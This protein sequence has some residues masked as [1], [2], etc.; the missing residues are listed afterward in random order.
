MNN[1]SDCLSIL[2]SLNLRV[3]P[4]QLEELS[5]RN[6]KKHGR[7]RRATAWELLRGLVVHMLGSPGTF[8]THFE[9][10]NGK[11]MAE[12]SL[13]ERRQMLPW[14][15]FS[16]LME[17]LLTPCAEKDRNSSAFYKGLRLVGIDGSNFSARNTKSILRFCTKALSRRFKAA[18]SKIGVSVLIELGTH[19][20]IGAAIAHAGESEWSLSKQVLARLPKESLLIGDKLFGLPSF[21]REF[22]ENVPEGKFL[23]RV[24]K[25]VL[26][27]TTK[28]LSDGSRL[29]EIHVRRSQK[30][31]STWSMVV[32][33]IRASVGR[34][35]HRHQEVRLWTNLTDEHQYPAIE[36]IELYA[37]RW[38]QELSY[39]EIKHQQ[40][41]GEL[42]DS[43][44]F[45]TVCQE[46]AA[47][48]IAASVIAHQRTN[49]AGNS[50]P[51]TA[52]GFEKALFYTQHLWY[53]LL[54]SDGILTPAQQQE[55]ANRFRKMLTPQTIPKKR[56]RSC[57]RAVRQPIKGWPRKN[58]QPDV[59]GAIN[60]KIF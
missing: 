34:R 1:K 13:S 28:K 46:I 18:F 43:Q 6:K 2:E 3:C 25:K 21:V 55:V 15:V 38:E 32:R 54:S 50:L 24:R 9:E 51:V 44:T 20:P 39:R 16:W 53:F 45:E 40:R 17:L 47:L 48:L 23:F 22:A 57:P 49:I 27:K 42:L 41:D 60:V 36:V 52:I 11:K 30:H 35:G 8:G 37:Q 4:E 5:E 58:N 31:T 29:V 10:A 12:S 19:N 33:E 7:P 56:S 26:S 14:E 59:T